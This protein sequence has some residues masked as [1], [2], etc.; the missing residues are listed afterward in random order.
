MTDVAFV[1][2]EDELLAKKSS[3]IRNLRLERLEFQ[4][5]YETCRD[6]CQTPLWDVPKPPRGRDV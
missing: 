1:V 6:E 4:A 2:R 5:L 3:A